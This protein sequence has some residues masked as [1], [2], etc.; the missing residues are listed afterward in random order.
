MITFF[1]TT[2]KA[3]FV[4]DV[5]RTIK[6]DILHLGKT[7]IVISVSL[8]FPVLSF[9]P[10]ENIRKPSVFWCFQGDQKATLGRKELRWKFNIKRD[11][12]DFGFSKESA[13][14]ILLVQWKINPSFPIFLAQKPESINKLKNT[15]FQ[16]KAKAHYS[17]L[18]TSK[19]K[20]EYL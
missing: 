1:T 10:P 9:Y 7:L 19:V 12:T 8:L 4:Y 11:F 17:S 16:C 5:I 15:L 2:K 13:D 6:C 18:E 3:I 20:L 14:H